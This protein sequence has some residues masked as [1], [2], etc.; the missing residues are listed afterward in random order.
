MRPFWPFLLASEQAAVFLDVDGTLAPI[1]DDPADAAV[2]REARDVLAR[3]ADRFALVACVTG[4][5][6]LTA[7]R[8]VG[9][10]GITYAGN[11]GLEVLDPGSDQPAT[12]PELAGRAE[13]A[14][15]LIAGLDA[16]ELAAAGLRLED[17]GP[18]QAIHWR[19]APDAERARREAE[20]IAAR[21][22]AEG[23]VPPWGRKVLELRPTSRVDKGSAVRSLL[24]G[25]GVD[26]AAFG[27]DDLTDLDAFD[28]LGHLVAEGE[29]RG[30][31]RIGVASEEAP[32]HLG[33]RADVV[34]DGTT[35]FLE[36]LRILAGGG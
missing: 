35:G 14:R 20:R 33:E 6:P 15:E 36:A 30:T 5:P 26:L 31:V 25:A 9:V 4:R 3:L 8:I 28:A 12:V 21:A 18:I 34:V 27:G 11:H 16:G 13:L 2:P 1:V 24:A 7:R 23:L 17:K 19:V 22:E 10:E 29:L 32:A